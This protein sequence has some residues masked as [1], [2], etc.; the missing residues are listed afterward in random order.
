MV[1]S[2]D[3]GYDFSIFTGGRPAKWLPC[4]RREMVVFC[5]RC[6]LIG[7]SPGVGC[8]MCAYAAKD[9]HIAVQKKQWVCFAALTRGKDL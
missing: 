6:V 9:Q 7:Q 5:V 1:R 4:E 8:V 3:A 2:K